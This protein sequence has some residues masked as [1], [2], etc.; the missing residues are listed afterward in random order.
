MKAYSIDL[1]QRIVAAWEGRV[2][3]QRAIAQRFSVSP[4]CV[5]KL[6]Q[7]Q[8]TTGSVAAPRH[9]AYKGRF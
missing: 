6:V 9:G 7:R 1:R 3:C 4:S 5:E 8:R 2:G